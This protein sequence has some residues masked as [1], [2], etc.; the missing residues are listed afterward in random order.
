MRELNSTEG[1]SRVCVTGCC[2]IAP[3]A[4]DEER[5]ARIT[6]STDELLSPERGRRLDPFS[7]LALI[8]VEHARRQALLAPNDRKCKL[9]TEGVALGSALGAVHTTV[10]YARR[11]VDVGPTATNP[12]DFPDSIDGAA[13]GHVALDLG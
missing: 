1:L 13:A 6:L 4:R 11:L 7:Q 9:G 3:V 5:I 10:R 12:I 2:L 8:A